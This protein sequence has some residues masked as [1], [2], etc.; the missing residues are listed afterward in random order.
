[1]TGTKVFNLKNMPVEMHTA[2]KI[3]AAELQ[4]GMEA[5]ALKYIEEGLKRDKGKKKSR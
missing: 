5:L 3:R 1:M 2:L 4:T